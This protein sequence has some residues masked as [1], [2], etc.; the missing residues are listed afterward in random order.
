MKHLPALQEDALQK[1]LSSPAKCLILSACVRHPMSAKVISEA[2]GQPL[3]STYRQ[4]KA[5][6]ADHVLI[7]E[8]SAMTADGKP[9]DLYRSRIRTARLEVGPDRVRTTWE[10]N[11]AIE[12]RI[13]T[14]WNRLGA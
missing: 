9:Y 11:H 13:A 2:T 4:I 10:A 7:V 14:M 3:A 1:A 6:V 8:R 12:D 5:L